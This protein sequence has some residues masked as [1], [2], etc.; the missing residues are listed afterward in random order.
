M[1]AKTT[2]YKKL[3][4]ELG[5]LQKIADDQ[6]YHHV[7]SKQLLYKGLSRVYMWWKEA[8]KENGLL[9]KL[10][11]EYNLQFKKHTKQEIS[12]SPLLRYL[13]NMDGSLKAATID[14][15]NK[16]LNNMHTEV[17]LKQQY[18]KTNTLDKLIT[19]ISSK[20]GIIAMADY[21]V[22]ENEVADNKNIVTKIKKL[23]KNEIQKLH[24]AHLHNGKNYFASST[25]IAQIKTTKTL[26]REDSGLT[27]ALMRKYKNG[28]DVVAAVDDNELIEAS[29]A[30]AYKRTSKQMPHTARLITEVI[31]SQTLPTKL[32]NL[33]P[34]LVDTG[35]YEISN[36]K[37]V[38]KQLK[39][40]MYVA[41][42][43]TFVLSANRSSCSVVTVATPTKQIFKKKEKENL[44]LSVNDRT[45][46]ENSLIHTNDFN[47]YTTDS[48]TY[49]NETSNETASYKMKLENTVTKYYRYIRF[50]KL[51]VYN[52]IPS[53]T[54]VIL[55][56][57]A[58]YKATYK[59]TLTPKWI[60]DM[61]MI[62]LIRW[63]V[64]RGSKIKRPQNTIMKLTFG[65]KSIAFHVD[66]RKDNFTEEYIVSYDKNTT[67][68]NTLCANVLSRDVVPVLNALVTM[69]INGNVQL[70][71]DD[72][73]MQFKFKTD[74]AKY[75]ISIPLCDHKGKRFGD[76]MEAYGS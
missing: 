16:A 3:K 59:A 61:N 37:E 54:Q 32:A 17:L 26:A 57:K 53:K 12:F 14:Q 71:A 66:K 25:P 13:W 5:E 52:S 20:G 29:I 42:N 70:A 1:A 44:A 74:C 62:F 30:L 60:G 21:G 47:F 41:S 48:K 31:R 28:Y 72:L 51:S 55:K 10:Y 69:E 67:A 8:N 23:D 68:N 58:K 46:I 19:L 9:E 18:F 6:K 7:S 76:Y 45:F 4:A 11:L 38:R 73:L 50:Y 27:L 65:K 43:G 39:R 24:N 40:L 15:Y 33:A 56:E 75:C 49:V 36:K 35:K 22:K 2:R 63:V 64:G 34:L